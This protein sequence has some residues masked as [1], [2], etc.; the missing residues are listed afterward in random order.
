M[1]IDRSQGSSINRFWSWTKPTIMGWSRLHLSIKSGS[2]IL[3]GHGQPKFSQSSTQRIGQLLNRQGEVYD[4]TTM[5]QHPPVNSAWRKTNYTAFPL[6]FVL[7]AKVDQ[8][9]YNNTLEEV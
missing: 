5:F 1:M 7:T 2:G 3:S 6:E 8:R 4:G 9:W